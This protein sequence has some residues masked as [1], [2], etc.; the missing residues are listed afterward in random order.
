MHSSHY[1]PGIE[2]TDRVQEQALKLLAERILEHAKSG[3]TRIILKQSQRGKYSYSEWI[4]TKALSSMSVSDLYER[5]LKQTKN[6]TKYV[7]I[8]LR[9][10][11]RGGAI[12]D[13]IK[14]NESLL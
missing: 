1:F 13:R 6:R 14:K 2:L 3:P 7:N 8:V 11:H 10:Q 5:L 9:Q 4:S 12:H